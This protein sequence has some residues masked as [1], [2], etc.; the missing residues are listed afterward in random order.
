MF[1]DVK[2]NELSI[3]FNFE[4][5]CSSTEEAAKSITGKVLKHKQKTEQILETTY[6]LMVEQS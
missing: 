4:S 3:K 1:F 6:N 2:D 5:M